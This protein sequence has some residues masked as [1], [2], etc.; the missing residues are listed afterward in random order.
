[1]TSRTAQRRRTGFLKP[2]ALR[3]RRRVPPVLLQVVHQ[4]A[5]TVLNVADAFLHGAL[6]LCL[7]VAGGVAV[8]LL[9][10][11]L[12]RLPLSANR[13][14]VHRCCLLLTGKLS[15]RRR[16][17]ATAGSAARPADRVA[18]ATA[19]AWERHSPRVSPKAGG[20]GWRAHGCVG[21]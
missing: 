12:E 18:G 2:R 1:M 16:T 5:D 3:R 20:G 19:L 8:V 13:V 14:F 6:Y 17:W 7:P 9:H 4:V 21:T 15:T 11:A 10:A